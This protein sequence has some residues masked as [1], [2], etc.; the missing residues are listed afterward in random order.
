MGSIPLRSLIRCPPPGNLRDSPDTSP[1]IGHDPSSARSSQ[2]L[3]PV[4][5]PG[6][7]SS[8]PCASCG[9]PSS[10]AQSS[11]HPQP[12]SRQGMPEPNIDDCAGTS[13][14]PN[15]KQPPS[16]ARPM[17][18]SARPEHMSTLRLQS[19]NIIPRP[20]GP[21]L[22]HSQTHVLRRAATRTPS[23]PHL[24]NNLFSALGNLGTG[25]RRRLSNN[26]RFA[27]RTSWDRRGRPC[28]ACQSTRGWKWSAGKPKHRCDHVPRGSASM[29][30]RM[31]C[32]WTGR[33]GA[34][35]EHPLAEVEPPGALGESGHANRSESRHRDNK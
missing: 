28:K 33:E 24:V 1:S 7:S 30:L 34:S 25:T 6:E 27:H 14:C 2:T 10:L 29:T 18:R 4:P 22:P 31:R 20:E 15:K 35:C 23:S 17:A 26:A 5:P 13:P 8:T 12:P 16:G 11:P 19:G 3:P 21:Q 9:D 32:P